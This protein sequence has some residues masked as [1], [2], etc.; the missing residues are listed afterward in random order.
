MATRTR[1][2]SHFPATEQARQLLA[3]ARYWKRKG[4]SQNKLFGLKLAVHILRRNRL[5]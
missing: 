2:S 4:D 3:Q 1:K 5:L